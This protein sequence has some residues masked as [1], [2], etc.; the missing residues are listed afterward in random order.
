[1]QQSG[2]WRAEEVVPLQ[3][4][5]DEVP[6]VGGWGGVRGASPRFSAFDPFWLN[7]VP[8]WRPQWQKKLLLHSKLRLRLKLLVAVFCGEELSITKT[9]AKTNKNKN[10]MARAD[11]M[12]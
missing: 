11:V 3:A 10:M 6:D 7:S 9:R 12:P 2:A 5:Q 1:M 4:A 8:F